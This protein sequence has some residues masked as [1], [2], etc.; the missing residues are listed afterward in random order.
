MQEKRSD[1]Y[2]KSK[3]SLREAEAVQTE[4]TPHDESAPETEDAAKEA[5]AEE[6]K[7][8]KSGK[9]WLGVLVAAV[10]CL[11]VIAVA[12][13]QSMVEPPHPTLN[14]VETP[15]PTATPT[16]T[17]EAKEEATETPPPEPTPKV[18]IPEMAELY[19]Q[20]NDL[21]AWIKIDGTIIDYPVMYTPNDGEFYLY[22]T[23]EKEEDPTKQG[24]VFI[25]EHCSVDPRGTNLL[26]H[27]HNM[28][29]G[30]MF[31]SLIEYENEEYY[32]QHP[33]IQFTTLYDQEE[34]EIVYAFHSRVY[35]QDDDVFKY[36]RFY[37][38]NTPEEFQAFVDGCR[39]L[40]FYDTGIEP[41][42]GDEFLT[43]NTCEYS[44]ENGRMVIVA[45]KV[46]EDG[47]QTD[48]IG[49]TLQPTGASTI[50]S[51][52]PGALNASGEIGNLSDEITVYGEISG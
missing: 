36:Y 10:A 13:A 20:N 16:P 34:Y 15:A 24:C 50:A 5:A 38:A 28:R 46:R 11:G 29:K 8:A 4:E 17:R 3:K 52:A 47:T 1:R 37:Q 27:G 30:T 41:V 45:R 43:M 44:V 40:S 33:R 51:S 18:M 25:D 35:D 9:M 26:L 14:I 42:F 6:R 12:A 19:A 48:I 2:R 21:A 7:R 22:R 39:A 32:R 31:H 49:P 23:F